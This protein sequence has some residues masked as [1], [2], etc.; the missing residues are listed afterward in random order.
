MPQ[1][2]VIIHTVEFDHFLEM[3]AEWKS[4]FSVICPFPA[5]RP[6]ELGRCC[7]WVLLKC[8]VLLFSGDQG[9]DGGP[10]FFFYLLWFFGLC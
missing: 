1:S 9:R 8:Y 3:E 7:S 10:F 5:C 6:Y 2:L 4:F